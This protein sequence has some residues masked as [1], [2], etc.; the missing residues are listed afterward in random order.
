M[1]SP[2]ASHR[3]KPRSSDRRREQP[4]TDD[5]LFYTARAPA[6]RAPARGRK[7]ES[8]DVD[9]DEE[10]EEDGGDMDVD[11]EIDG[12]LSGGEGD[13]GDGDDGGDGEDGGDGDGDGDDGK[14]EGS[15]R[16]C[17]WDECP[18]VFGD[19]KGLVEHVT[20]DH[21]A[22]G[23]QP[24]ACLWRTCTRQG[25]KQA[26]RHALLTHI[27]SHTGEKPYQCPH[28]GCGRNFTR[29]DAMNKHLRA[30]HGPES[31]NKR[32]RTNGAA[33]EFAPSA[34]DDEPAVIR[35][36]AKD[37]DLSEVIHRLRSRDRVL[38]KAANA[39]EE[40]AL[41][42]VRERRPGGAPTKRGGRAKGRKSGAAGA[43]EDKNDSDPGSDFD[44]G[45]SK[46]YPL[47]RQVEG[48]M[49]DP[50]GDSELAVMGR[51]RWQAKYI[52]AKAKL[53][54]VDEENKMRR[55]E[56]AFWL[57]E[58]ERV[59]GPRVK[60]ESDDGVDVDDERDERAD[61]RHRRR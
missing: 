14:D 39:D 2:P 36:L 49:V 54:L 10:D 11:D 56:L 35:D 29:S 28:P 42:Y 30:I 33:E 16:E 17:Q 20:K 6:R 24:Y 21:I 57:E 18:R 59:L 60:A 9:E 50:Q 25:Q 37:E 40:A 47:E 61:D 38:F 15:A 43:D 7:Q 34:L 12:L 5:E 26:S 19:Q 45:A 1:S 4:T 53:M 44:E 48:Y 55:D 31:N 41:R 13:G 3:R 52:M 8:S 51:S 46:R 27:R 58:E 22:T 23:R 32:R